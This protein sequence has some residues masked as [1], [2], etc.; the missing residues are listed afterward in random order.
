MPIKKPDAITGSMNHHPTEVVELGWGGG[1]LVLVVR[2]TMARGR[3][4][5]ISKVM[6]KEKDGGDRRRGSGHHSLSPLT[7]PGGVAVSLSLSLSISTP[8]P[9]RLS[10]SLILAS[11]LCGDRRRG[12]S[13]RINHG[14]SFHCRAEDSEGDRSRRWRGGGSNRWPLR[15]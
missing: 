7:Q 6:M 9:N 2:L 3:S 1:G 13:S 5:G 8:P 14:S 12:I 11:S 4:T 10:A 15:S